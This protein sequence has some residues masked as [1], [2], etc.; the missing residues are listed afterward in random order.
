[1]GWGNA[2]NVVTT[3][4]DNSADDPSLARADLYAAL[5][6]LTAVING[7]NS[8]NGV[9][10][11]D[12]SSLIPAAR[13]PDQLT[14]SSGNNMILAPDTDRVAIQDIL[15]LAALTVTQ[16][17][18]LTAI[19]GDLAYCSNGN[20]GAKCLAFYDGSTWKRIALGTTI[21]AT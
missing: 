15:N 5:L 21:S 20:A 10:G 18:A 11:L 19:T 6:E 16:L 3:N 9:C 8:T 1:M 14:T 13:L 12:S 2:S 7:R 17:N 4:L